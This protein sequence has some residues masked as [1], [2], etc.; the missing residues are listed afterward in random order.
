MSDECKLLMLIVI[1]ITVLEALALSLLYIDGAVFSAVI[2][3]LT[4]IALKREYILG[5]LS[6]GRHTKRSFACASRS[7]RT[8]RVKLRK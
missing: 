5:R 1:A 7:N 8:T 6:N 3:S 2:G 4:A